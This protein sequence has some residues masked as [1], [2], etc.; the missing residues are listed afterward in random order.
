[1]SFVDPNRAG[2][3]VRDSAVESDEEMTVFIER[4]LNEL[5]QSAVVGKIE[6][7]EP[8]PLEAAD[9]QDQLGREAAFPQFDPKYLAFMAA[10]KDHDRVG[11]FGRLPPIQEVE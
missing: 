6:F 4:T 3:W 7:V 1:M 9:A 2:L 11:A 8:P 5:L 10:C